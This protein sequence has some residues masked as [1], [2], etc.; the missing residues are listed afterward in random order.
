MIKKILI[1]VYV[2]LVSSAT[3]FASATGCDYNG[4]PLKSFKN[5]G[6]TNAIQGNAQPKTDITNPG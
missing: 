6:P 1:I 3:I 4:N 2:A 5:C